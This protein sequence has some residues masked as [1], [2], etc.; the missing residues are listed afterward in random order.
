MKPLAGLWIDHLDI[1]LT[2]PSQ[3]APGFRRLPE[4]L[5]GATFRLLAS[6]V[7]SEYLPIELVAEWQILQDSIKVES[8]QETRPKSLSSAEAD[9]GFFPSDVSVPESRAYQ[10]SFSPR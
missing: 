9:G 8:V 3:E 2:Q 1:E 7:R 10:S 5:G 4:T 6:D